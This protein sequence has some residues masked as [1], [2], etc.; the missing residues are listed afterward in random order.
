MYVYAHVS[1]DRAW[2]FLSFFFLLAVYLKGNICALIKKSQFYIAELRKSLKLI[3][4]NIIQ[5]KNKGL[6][7]VTE[8][9]SF[10]KIPGTL[11]KYL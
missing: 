7:E 4:K 8:M 10:C 9:S 11:R 3:F 5:G 1:L 6:P 2:C